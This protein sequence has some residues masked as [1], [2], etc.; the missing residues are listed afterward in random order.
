MRIKNAQYLKSICLMV[1]FSC[2]LFETQAANFTSTTNGDWD[3]GATWGNPGNNVSG[4]GYP[5]VADNATITSGKT[6]QVKFDQSVNNITI[7]NG[8]LINTSNNRD[9]SVV[10]DYI[11]NGTHTGGNG[12]RVLLSGAAKTISGAGIVSLPGGVSVLTSR[13]ILT[14]SNLSFACD[15]NLTN[16][17]TITNNGAV[18]MVAP[19]VITAPS[20]ATWTNAANST[21]SVG[22]AIN[23]L[24]NVTL[25]ASAVGNTVRYYQST[26]QNIKTPSSNTYYNLQI[27]GTGAKTQLAN[28]TVLGDIT[29]SSATLNMANFSITLQGNWSNEGVLAGTGTVIFNGGNAQSVSNSSGEVFYRMTMAKTA[30]YLTMLNDVS[31]SNNLT[32]TSG[33]IDANLNVLSIGISTATLGSLTYT[34]GFVFNGFVKRW[35]N[36]TGVGLLFPMG[37]QYGS[38]YAPLKI[39][40]NNLASSGALMVRFPPIPGASNNGLPLVDGGTTVYNTFSQGVYTLTP[41]NGLSSNNYN[42]EA[43]GLPFYTYYA[44][45][46]LLARP[47]AASNW[48]ANGTH[49]AGTA[50]TGPAK[51]ANM[52]MLPVDIALADTV[53]CSA[54]NTAPFTGPRSVCLNTTTTYSVP[55]TGNPYLWV[56]QGG[57]QVSGGFSNTITVQWGS[58]GTTGV[59]IVIEQSACGSGVPYYDFISIEPTT[60]QTISGRDYAAENTTVGNE[61]VYSV[62]SIP[63]YTYAWSVTGG[64]V[65]SGGSTNSASVLWGPAGPGQVSVAITNGCGTTTIVKPVTIYIVINSIASGSWNSPS[66]WDCNCIPAAINTVRVRNPHTVTLPNSDI[67]ITNLLSDLGGTFSNTTTKTLTVTGDI[68]M[69]GVYTGT[70][71]L[72]QVGTGTISGV[73]SITTTG[74]FVISG[75]NKTI[76][77]PSSLTISSNISIAAG[78]AINNRGTVYATGNIIGAASNSRWLNLSN[79]VLNVGGSFLTTGTVVAS[80]VPNTIEYTGSGSQNI[81]LTNYYNLYSSGTGARVLPS[82]G[83]VGIAGDFVAGTNAYT[84]TGSTVN[85]LGTDQTIPAFTFNDLTISGGGIKTLTG[86]VA[87]NG[88]L[89]LTGG[90]VATGSNTLTANAGALI[91]RSSGHVNGNLQRWISNTANTR[92]D[93]GTSVDY[94]QVFIAFSSVGTPGFITMKSNTGDHASIASSC[95]D[96]TK[97]VNNNITITN[98]SATVGA[99]TIEFDYPSSIVDLAATPP[100]FNVKA[101]NAGAW[102][103]QFTLSS[104]PTS[105]QT[106]ISGVTTFGDFQIG[107]GGISF[108]IQ[109]TPQAVCSGI[110]VTFSVA[111]N[112]TTPTYQWQVFSS[113]SWSTVVN[114]GVYSN[115][116][117]SNLTIT[118]VLV[119]MD[120]YQYRCLVTGTQCGGISV[121][122]NAALLTVTPAAIAVAGTDVSSCSNVASV[123]IT[124]GSSTLNQS[125]RLWTSSGTGTFTNANSLS[126][127]TYT[128]SAADKSAGSV[129][130]T[131]TAGGVGVC[132]AAT[133]TKTLTIGVI[134]TVNAG[135]TMTIC[136]PVATN[137][138]AGSSATNF[139]TLTWSSNGSGIFANVNS[140]TTATYTPSVADMSAGSRTLTLTATGTGS[141]A[142]VTSNKTITTRALPVITVQPIDMSTCTG[143]TVQFKVTATGSSL[144]Y[145]WLEN[146]VVLTNTG[147][148]SGVTTNTLNLTG[149]TAPN[150]YSVQVFSNG[151]LVT[152]TVANLTIFATAPGDPTVYGNGVWNCYGY[153]AINFTNYSGYYIEPLFSFD[154]R[155]RWTSASF[156]SNASGYQGC[157]MPANN[158]SISMKRTGFTTGS[159]TA[160]LTGLDDGVR[161]F[162][163]GVQVYVAGCCISSAQPVFWTG[164]LTPTSQVEL[165]WTQGGGGSYLA[166]NFT[167]I[168]TPVNTVD[169]GSIRGDQSTCLG[170]VPTQVLSNVI[171]ASATGCTLNSAY[172]WQSSTDSLI[173]VDISGANAAAYTIPAALSQTTWYRRAASNFCATVAYSNPVKVYMFPTAPG[174]P[175]V[176]GNNVWNA[177]VYDFSSTGYTSADNNWTDYKGVFTTPGISTA[178]Q[179][180]NSATIYNIA[181]NPSSVSTYQ[182]CLVGAS[183]SGAQFKRQGF[184]D[185]TYQIDFNSDDAGYLYVNGV[186]VYGRTGC[187]TLVPNV[188]TGTLNATSTVEYRYK[189]SGGGALAF[190]TIT[191]VT[192]TIPLYGGLISLSGPDT[193]CA[194]NIPAPI[195]TTDPALS[196]CSITYQWEAADTLGFV[197][198]VGATSANYTATS[199]IGITTNYRR[200]VMDACGQIT[201]TNIVAVNVGPTTPTNPSI[202]GNNEWIAYV[203]GAPNYNPAFLAGS[204]VDVGASPTDPSFDSR[205][206]WATNSTPSL[207][208]T[209]IGCQIG[210]DNHSVIYKRQGFPAGTYSISEINDDACQLYV[211]GVLVYTRST[212]TPTFIIGVG[213]VYLDATSTV[214]FRWTEGGGG[215][216]GG[217]TFLIVPTPAPLVAG[218]IANTS[219]TVCSGDIP[220]AFTSSAAATSGCFITYQWQQNTGSGYTNISGANSATYTPTAITVPTSYRRFVTD[221]CS[222]IDSSNVISIAIGAPLPLPNPAVFG[223]NVWNVYAYKDITFSTLAGTYVDNGFSSSNPSFDSRNSWASNSTP[224]AAPGYVGCQVGVDFHGVIY[225]RQGFPV[226][227]YQLDFL[228]DDAGSV[229]IDGVLVY[230]SVGCCVVYPNIWTGP[231]NASSTVEFRW[232]D[233]GGGAS[234]GQLTM[235]VPVIPTPLLG[236]TIATTTPIVCS[237]NVPA[238]ITSTVDASGGCYKSYQ[239]ES[240]TTGAYS[241]IAGATNA[242]YT[243][244]SI[245]VTTTY[246]RKVTDVC[247]NA[248]TSNALVVTVGVA[249]APDT[250]VYGSNVWK[251]YVYNSNNFGSVNLYGSYTDNGVSAS[252]PSFDTRLLWPS[253]SRPSVAPGYSGCQVGDDNHSVIYKRQG[254]PTGNYTIDFNSDDYGYLYVNGVLVY[255]R[256]TGCCT[257]VPAVWT[258]TLNA[259]SKI[260]YRYR[261]FAGGSFGLLNIISTTP[262]PLV[263]GTI[264]ADQTIC[265]STIP[266]AFTSVANATSGCAITYQWQRSTISSTGPWT[267]V[268]GNSNVYTSGSLTTGTTPT[269]YYFRRSATD[270]STTGYSNVIVVTVNP[271]P[272]NAGTITGVTAVCSGQTGVIYSIPAVANATSYNWILPTGSTITSGTGTNSIAVTFGATSGNVRVQPVNSCGLGLFSTIAVTVTPGAPGAA[273]AISGVNTVCSGQFSVPF[274]IVAVANATSYTW[275]VPAGASIISGA[276]T[277]AITVTFGSNPGN[278]TVTPVNGCGSGTTVSKAVTISPLPSAAGVITGSGSIC[279]NQTGVV[280]SIAAVANATS[281]S[282]SLP[283][284]ATIASGGTTNSIT[285]NFGTVAGSIVVTPINACGNGNTSAKAISV[286]SLPNSPAAIT[287]PVTVCNGN[288]NKLYT[289][290]AVLYATSY[291]WTVPSGST[292]TSGLGTNTIRVTFGA[293]SGNVTVTPSNSCGVGATSSLAVTVY[294]S[295]PSAAGSITGLTDVCQNDV[296]VPYSIAPVANAT[297]YNYPF[298][299]SGSVITS[300]SGTNAITLT[301]GTA[302]GTLT[303]RPSNAC[304]AGATS[305][306]AITVNPPPVVAAG[307]NMTACTTDSPINIT[308]GSSATNTSGI[309]WTCSGTGGIANATSLTNAL[310]S[311][312]PADIASGTVTIIL[313]ANGL[314]TCGSVVSTKTLTFSTPIAQTVSGSATL[315]IGS[316]T[317]YTA[318]TVG[319]TWTSGTPSIAIVNSTTGVVT[320]VAAGTSSI[321]YSVTTTG[322]CVNTASQTITISA[323]IAQT[324]SGSAT[325]CVGSTTTY[326]ATTAGGTWSSGTP[327]VAT[328]NSA[329]GVVTGVAAGTSSIT[330]TVT[331]AGGCVNTANQTITINACSFVW[332]GAVSTAWNLAGN[333]STSLIPTATDSVLIPAGPSNMPIVSAGSNAEKVVINSGASL[334]IAAGGTLNVYGDFVNTGIV[335]TVPTSTINMNGAVAQTISGLSNVYNLTVNNTIGVSVLTP[336]VINGTVSLT[337]GVFTTNSNV[338]MNFDNG[339]N[340]KYAVSDAGSVS[341][342]IS[343][344]RDVVAKT[345]YIAAPF[346]GSTSLQVAQTT[347]IYVAPYWKMYSRNFTAQNWVAVINNTTAMPLGTG[348]S[349]SFPTAAPLVLTGTYNHAYTFSSATY[350]NSV[351]GKYILVGNPYPSTLDWNNG[352]GWTKTNIG[353]ALYYWDA[354]NAQTGSYVAGV[355]T[356]GGTQ[357]I[358][359]MQSFLV[360]TTGGGGTASLNIN[361]NARIG[362]QNP[363]YWRVSTDETIRITLQAEHSTQKDEAVIRFNDMATTS[364]DADLDA[365]KIMNGGL[366]PSVYTTVGADLYSINSLADA[367]SMT[368][369]PV[370]TKLPVDGNY[371]L[372]IQNSDPSKVYVLID[373]KLGTENLV[374]G[375]S[376]TFSGLKTDDANRFELQLRVGTTTSN[377]QST[378][379][380]NGLEIYSSAKGFVVQTSQFGG[381]EAEIEILD[382][383]GVTM[384]VYHKKVLSAGAT[385]VP[386]EIADGAYIVKVFVDGKSFAQ[387]ITIVK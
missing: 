131:L 69:N 300:G 266:A 180:F 81:A 254:F 93:I 17:I 346:S 158:I 179:G 144:T 142:N 297:S 114:G 281:Y 313:T 7:N 348:F 174:D 120:T 111:S 305:S 83:T 140:L 316:T 222:R 237:G 232:V 227:T 15:L 387:L 233:S 310:Y 19:G 176:F 223:S 197:D 235:I 270:C 184:P 41:L 22:A 256:T 95:F 291:V 165:R 250:T 213:A 86:N 242:T 362:L 190:L 119:S 355:S 365:G 80:A 70:T 212:W 330:Y 108:S 285:V 372:D 149:V 143:N 85:F 304:G 298:K 73:G 191:P 4:S 314:A 90:I 279:P 369:I 147:I 109:P 196:S 352:A 200:R 16:G 353:D 201:Y 371:S 360:R 74:T 335:T 121:V 265:A 162:V 50:V 188:W 383:T 134:P 299:P 333:W 229:Y 171:A 58:T 46:R 182:G 96:P 199:S 172:Q 33:E 156:P 336:V 248:S 129:T 166:I 244:T 195:I 354:A 257:L 363:S 63:G 226:G 327:A 106:I 181:N 37:I 210:V 214:E 344:R 277:N 312:S 38:Y 359:A 21:L 1:F 75:G 28:L 293:T 79:A 148:Y 40:F 43:V 385:F 6:V 164:T 322:G 36:A 379:I 187:C 84:I 198:I 54:P 138:T 146:G 135:T 100:N 178:N 92:F 53:N 25:N 224:S 51:R 361:N 351:A 378:S 97:S 124:A 34:G 29:I 52:T 150:N 343:G 130:L 39:T 347:P 206:L 374:S 30:G 220:N 315:C 332:T 294:L 382:M 107:E 5:G 67:F 3:N 122:S 116:T 167:P 71:N 209:Y 2:C 152:S 77:N 207:A 185:S 376:Y 194:G 12:S 219:T 193:I 255:S 260:E 323:P 243:P 151:C 72:I 132:L 276:T 290:P 252:D 103:S 78:V 384:G 125:S 11:N 221:A 24:N 127:A 329:T 211:N 13:S 112:A 307:S 94:T 168:A 208:P 104:A 56:V 373:K 31:V 292:I 42:A 177:Y 287:G 317:T 303:I 370:A 367:Y 278:V 216:F 27:S 102:S 145:Q 337:A 253:S 48:V 101:Y 357:F 169:A 264:A 272:S 155:N 268:G 8:G 66:T 65:V 62:P 236:G 217:L 47:N 239:W 61:E 123:N 192:P 82:T 289:I 231:L 113:G 377:G 89:R 161:M 49:Q 14:G 366:V 349:V 258:G 88:A 331:T 99:A 117:T 364:F 274:S 60:T 238:P 133:S 334:S 340:I 282:W 141:C 215:S 55:N 342:L 380:A 288:V 275:T 339:G 98:N 45:T 309:N 320:G 68:Q 350:D 126:I 375:P 325:L 20:S 204:Y 240:K 157:T 18:T 110:T 318:T 76:T 341:G 386:L 159:Y 228:T 246:R 57:I 32:L 381:S 302:S 173:W 225:K 296:S 306:I 203:Y 259:S 324:V 230:T 153:S 59:L 163:D 87:F 358:P 205:S 319:G 301:M 295:V 186:L 105:S 154:T 23:I 283:T 356:N 271:L 261:E 280:Y 218:A 136:G 262:A 345:H 128:P 284:G 26:A 263:A 267:N 368:I 241:N 35:V 137:I 308:T 10:G 234:Y 189:N 326:T 175:T 273:G 202:Y 160:N 64:T 170:Q 311:P 118:G 269:L 338:T 249:A 245:V 247:S 91:A 321:M 251:A 115:A 139:S 44:S 328:V 183:L 286:K 9:L